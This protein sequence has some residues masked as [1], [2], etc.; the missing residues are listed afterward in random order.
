VALAPAA[1][2]FPPAYGRRKPKDWYDIAFVPTTISA[3]PTRP[4]LLLGAGSVRSW[5]EERRPVQTAFDDLLANFATPDAQGPSAFASQML[6]DHPGE[7]ESQLRADAVLAVR[8]LHAGLLGT[9]G[10]R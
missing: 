7:D 8:T 6:V 5:L 10:L 9:M 2:K 3:V 4:L 1:I